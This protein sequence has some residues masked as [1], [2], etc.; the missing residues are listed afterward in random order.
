MLTYSSLKSRL[1][2]ALP[3]RA[4]SFPN[5]TLKLLMRISFV[6]VIISPGQ[7]LALAASR[8][9]TLLRMEA[10][11]QRHDCDSK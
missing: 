9:S 1:R 7:T 3:I 8:L 2:K 4:Q 5:S 6:V 11:G 10:A